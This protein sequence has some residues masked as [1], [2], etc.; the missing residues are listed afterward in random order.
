MRTDVDT[1]LFRKLRGLQHDV[2]IAGVKA[3]RDVDTAGEAKH[4]I[5]V[6]HVPRTEAL[7]EITVE[8]DGHGCAS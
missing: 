7:A 2:G 1:A 8:I 5:V 6:A 4:R 3:A